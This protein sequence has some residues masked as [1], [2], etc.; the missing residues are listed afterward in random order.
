MKAKRPIDIALSKSDRSI[1]LTNDVRDV[2]KIESG[3]MVFDKRS[4]MLAE[5]SKKLAQAN[6]G[7]A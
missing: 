7:F 3:E 1:C 6:D 5:L 2:E 4:L